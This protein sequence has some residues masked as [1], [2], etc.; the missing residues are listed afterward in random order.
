MVMDRSSMHQRRMRRNLKAYNRRAVEIARTLEAE[1]I[2]VGH[3]AT[4]RAPLS[5]AEHADACSKIDA[6]P[7]VHDEMERKR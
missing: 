4:D 2:R 6:G 7:S 1:K 5:V 3:P